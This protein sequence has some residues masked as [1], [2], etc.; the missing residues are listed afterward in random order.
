EDL[1]LVLGRGRILN[2]AVHVTRYQEGFAIA[3]SGPISISAK[4]LPVLTY[5]LESSQQKPPKFFWRTAVKPQDI[6]AIDIEPDTSGV[7]HLLVHPSWQGEIIEIGVTFYGGQGHIANIRKLSLQPETLGTNIAALWHGWTTFRPWSQ[8]SV[9]WQ[10]GG[11]AGLAIPAPILLTLWLLTSLLL[12][13]LARRLLPAR[14]STIVVF[15]LCV[16]LAWGLIDLR[17]IANRLEQAR[18]TLDTE[19]LGGE[20]ACIDIVFDC[21]LAD[22]AV[23][24][25]G[26]LAAGQGDKVLIA[27]RDTG[28]RFRALRMKY[29]LLPSPAIIY[30]VSAAALPRGSENYILLLKKFELKGGEKEGKKNQFRLRKNTSIATLWQTPDSALYEVQTRAL[31]N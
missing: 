23:K 16:L 8:T 26:Q 9:N 20:R 28:D 19:E 24:V 11:R 29:R 6:E 17:W 30:K 21:K 14:K 27:Y 25:R 4:D 31:K 10:A 22:L 2:D 1:K 12:Y 15:S 13:L 5:D 7:L 18:L 3:S